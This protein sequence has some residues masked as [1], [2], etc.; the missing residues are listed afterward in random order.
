MLSFGISYAGLLQGFRL[1]E[2][3]LSQLYFH[4]VNIYVFGICHYCVMVDLKK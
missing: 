3:L 1:V 4:Y 2:C